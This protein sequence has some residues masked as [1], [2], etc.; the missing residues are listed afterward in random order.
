MTYAVRP[1]RLPFNVG[2]P[3]GTI[4]NVTSVNKFGFNNNCDNGID[5][6]IWDLT[7]QPIWLPPTAP[8][9]HAIVSDQAADD[10][11]AGASARTIRIYGLKDWDSKETF[12]DISLQGATPVNTLNSYV[13]I[14]RMVVLTSGATSVNAG[15]IKATAASDGT[16]T[17]QIDPLDGQTEMAIYGIPSTQDAYMTDY[18]ASLLRSAGGASNIVSDVTLLWT[19]DVESQPKIYQIKSRITCSMRGASN[20]EHTFNPYQMFVGPGIMKI[21]ANTDTDDMG[22]SAGFDL[23][24][25][26]K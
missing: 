7:T 25:V 4:P 2:C 11:D 6:D 16:I 3:A 19:P 22:V 14:H 24:L 9:I 10:V 1:D 8:R 23:I 5:T 15:N 21:Q 13:I 18:Y 12:E 26:D 20:W 17:A